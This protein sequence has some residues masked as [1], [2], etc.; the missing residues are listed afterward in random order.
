MFNKKGDAGLVAIVIIVLILV[1]F[2][3]LV[4]LGSRECNSNSECGKDF[5]CGVDHGCHKI[6]V[7]ERSP[8]VVERDY[9]KP[10]MIIGAAIV[11]ASIFFNFDKLRISRKPKNPN[12]YY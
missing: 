2:G 10:S 4:N 8:V 6:P 11:I 9:T 12:I 5:Y 1:F 3:W 7:I